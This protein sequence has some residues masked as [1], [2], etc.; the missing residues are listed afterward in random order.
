MVAQETPGAPVPLPLGVASGAAAPPLTPATSVNRSD[1]PGSCIMHC[2]STAASTCTSSGSG[3]CGTHLRL[4]SAL[5]MGDR[6]CRHSLMAPDRRA[7][8]KNRR[9]GRADDVACC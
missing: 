8:P 9:G 6:D 3:S 2:R 1:Q 5:Y 7:P 4:S